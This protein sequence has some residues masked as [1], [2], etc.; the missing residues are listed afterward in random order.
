MLINI[1]NLLRAFTKHL[2]LKIFK[3]Y[4]WEKCL[5]LIQFYDSRVAQYMKSYLFFKRYSNLQLF[6]AAD[7]IE[8]TTMMNRP[9]T[10]C[11]LV[12]CCVFSV[13]VRSVTSSSVDGWLV[14]PFRMRSTALSWPYDLL[15]EVTSSGGFCM[16][17]CTLLMTLI[18][19]HR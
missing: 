11:Q 14:C 10:P 18:F 8:M 15:L 17:A 5:Q 13:C 4:D 1:G 6:Q 12:P 9:H 7:N 3:N 2:K 19:V 16:S